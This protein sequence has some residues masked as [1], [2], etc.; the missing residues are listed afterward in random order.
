MTSLTLVR[1]IKARPSIVIDAITT[2]DGLAW[3]FGPDNGPVLLAECDAKVGG[4]FRVRFRTMDGSIHTCGGEYLNITPECVAMSWRWEGASEDPG[5]SRLEIRL[6][7]IPEG[8]EL[9]LIHSLLHDEESRKAHERGWTGSLD[10]L[11]RHFAEKADQRA[12]G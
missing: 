11:E 6:R 10:K 2:P 8:T 9:T 4:C 7:A 3:W 5:R 1:R 12:Q